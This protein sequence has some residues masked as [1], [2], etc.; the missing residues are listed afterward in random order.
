MAGG[1][2]SEC[3]DQE[4]SFAETMLAKVRINGGSD[5]GPESLRNQRHR[6]LCLLLVLLTTINNSKAAVS[7]ESDY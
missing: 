7:T 4:M 5:G 3:W 2:D 1:Q 6:E